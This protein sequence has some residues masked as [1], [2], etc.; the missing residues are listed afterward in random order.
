[1]IELHDIRLVAGGL[2][3]LNIKAREA[4]DSNGNKLS[5]LWPS[6]KIKWHADDFIAEMNVDIQ[7]NE[8]S[9]DR[10][11]LHFVSVE[12]ILW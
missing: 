1:M 5:C 11:D 10:R 2:D 8:A 9:G 6:G 3:E 4:V 7:V 12:H